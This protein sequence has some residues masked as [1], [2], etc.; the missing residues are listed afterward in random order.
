MSDLRAILG[1]L[2]LLT[3]TS[4]A[5]A[6]IACVQQGLDQLGFEPGPVDGE[7]GRRTAA[8]AIAFSNEFGIALPDLRRA[9]NGVT[10]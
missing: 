3:T 8:A 5:H 6:Q 1:V 7:F 2:A 4:A 10:R 9:R